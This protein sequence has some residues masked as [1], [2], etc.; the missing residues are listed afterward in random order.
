M[1]N[2][3]YNLSSILRDR[4][5]KIDLIR[6]DILLTPLSPKI[7][8]QMRWDIMIDRIY[9]SLALADSPLTKPEM[10]KILT[11]NMVFEKDKNF[12]KLSSEEENVLSYKRALDYISQHWLVPEKN[13]TVKDVL[14]LYDIFYRGRLILPPSRIQEVLDYIQA[15]EDHPIIQAGVVCLGIVRIQPFSLGNGRLS[16]LLS[17]VFLYKNGYDVK[18]L[19]EFE[20]TW[21]ADRQT[22][23]EA[24][25]IALEVTSITLWLE[26]FSNSVLTALAGAYRK[27]NT[28][29]SENVGVHSSFWELSDR[30]KSIINMLDQPGLTITNRKVQKHFG[31]SQITA[32]RDLS[33][34]ASLGILFTHGKGRSVY[35]TKV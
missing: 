34:L 11:S 30:Q 26:Y 32:S 3:S 35:Y 6:K 25:R 33:H 10:I 7:E 22:Y 16:R 29:T 2:L 9:N 15:H 27:I 13:V 17:Y 12:K 20:K 4:L 5:Q 23:S 14:I 28:L 8:L 31:I 21:T 1:L 24:I 18:G 19:I